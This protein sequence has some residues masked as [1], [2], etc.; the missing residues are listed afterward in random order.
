MRNIFKKKKE[1]HF[2]KN[3]GEWNKVYEEFIQSSE[4]SFITFL[5]QKYIAPIKI[6]GVK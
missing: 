5:K 2:V 1:F 3:V 4:T 6:N